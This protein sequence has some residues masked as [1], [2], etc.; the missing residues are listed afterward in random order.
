MLIPQKLPKTGFRNLARTLNIAQVFDQ[1]NYLLA[2]P[3]GLQGPSNFRGLSVGSP[4]QVFRMFPPRWANLPEGLPKYNATERV[5]NIADDLSAAES[6]EK[7]AKE[8]ETT[9]GQ[10][11]AQRLGEASAAQ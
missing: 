3:R 6:A 7:A 5:L 4:E 1:S 2:L 8:R 10:A 11:L 9:E